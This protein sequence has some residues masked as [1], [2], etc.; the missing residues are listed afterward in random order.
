MKI[1]TLATIAVVLALCIPC[2]ATAQSV[3]LQLKKLEI[4]WGDANVKKDVAVLDRIMADDYTETGIDGNVET[5][6]QGMAFVKSGEY[7]LSSY[8]YSDMKVR[9]YGDTAVVTFIN[10]TKD[11]YKGRNISGTSRWTDTWIKRGGSWQCVASHSSK[12]AHP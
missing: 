7:V 5:K 10:K 4:Q 8:A 6:A 9:V 12:V 11:T 3:E 2:L 1:S